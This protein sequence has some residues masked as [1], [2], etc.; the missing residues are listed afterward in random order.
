MLQDGL[1]SGLEKQIDRMFYQTQ[2][3]L[4]FFPFS[5]L[6]YLIGFILS[7]GKAQVPLNEIKIMEKRYDQLLNRDLQNVTEGLY[8]RELL[9]QMPILDYLP[10]YPAL[11]LDLL[12]MFNRAAHKNF[13]DLP[14][15]V[16]D[17]DYPAYYKRNFHWQTDG[18]FS[19]H[20]A[21]LYDAS[22]ELLFLGTADIMRRQIIPPVSRFIRASAH[23]A[24]GLRLL[25]VACGTGRTLLQLSRTH[26][27]LE[28][29]GLD[30]SPYYIREARR[31]LND[32]PKTS[33]L[34]VNAEN[35]P[36][37]DG[38]FDI[39]TCVYLFHELPR[40]VRRKVIAEMYRVLK[41]GGLLVIEDSCQLAESRELEKTMTLFPVEYHEPFYKDYISDDLVI[42]LAEAGFADL[43]T[44]VHYLSKVFIA[45]KPERGKL[46]VNS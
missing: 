19:N 43:S 1:I 4:L 46:T 39:L 22:V 27:Q 16:S 11:A 24:S 40:K 14:G 2:Q 34:H 32:V 12:G 45:S 29:F 36:L 13:K 21:G 31:V 10:K 6:R 38:Y 7:Q 8:P 9:Y 42:P 28:Y 23:E 37:K 30:L 15:S 20:S 33:L 3:R 26:P 18:Y 25:D 35:I 44:E 41:P 5:S 17:D